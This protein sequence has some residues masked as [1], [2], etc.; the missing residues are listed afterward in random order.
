MGE[1]G[2]MVWR[3]QLA[4]VDNGLNVVDGEEGKRPIR[5]DDQIFGLSTWVRWWCHEV[6]WG[7]LGGKQ[8]SGGQEV[9][10]EINDSVWLH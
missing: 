2:D 8:V 4:A 9:Q 5:D 1:F 3:T 7:N 10:R 6:R